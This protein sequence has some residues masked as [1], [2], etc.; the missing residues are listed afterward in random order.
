MKKLTFLLTLLLL[1]ITL[2]SQNAKSEFLS[3]DNTPLFENNDSY[4]ASLLSEIYSTQKNNFSCSP[5][6]LYFPLAVMANGASGLTKQS[7]LSYLSVSSEQQLNELSIKLISSLQSSNKEPNVLTVANGIFSHNEPIQTFLK[8]VEPLSVFI[9]KLKSAKQI[10]DWVSS[11]TKGLIKNIIEEL[12]PDERVL[13]INAIYFK[14]KWKHPFKKQDTYSGSF[15]VNN[16]S[17]SQVKYMK[18][19]VNA[20][21]FK[22]EEVSILKYNYV[23]N[24]IYALF[25]LPSENISLEEYIQKLSYSKLNKYKSKME[26]TQLSIHIPK[27]DIKSKIDFNNILKNMGLSRMFSDNNELV[28]LTNENLNV[29]KIL[30]V[31]TVTVDESGAEAAAVTVSFSQFESFVI[32]EPVNFKLD[33]PFLF[34]IYHIDSDIPM[35]ISVINNP[36]QNEN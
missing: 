9:D 13:I 6:S 24:D 23:N 4:V 14:G 2:T 29:K 19:D 22:S 25:I 11:N 26:M 15:F 16:N 27:F 8:K 34:S 36:E 21:Y 18:A 20:L 1:N 33:R 28:G 12:T 31:A 5:I 17:I 10:N 30:Q 32:F 3:M 35:F 7:L